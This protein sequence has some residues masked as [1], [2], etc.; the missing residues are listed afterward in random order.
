MS[1]VL[2]QDSNHKQLLLI[3]LKFSSWTK[4]Q[5]EFFDCFGNLLS[6]DINEIYFRVANY[7]AI[8]LHLLSTSVRSIL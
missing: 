4:A 7:A 5:A 6:N 1:V 3:D 2:R 8:I